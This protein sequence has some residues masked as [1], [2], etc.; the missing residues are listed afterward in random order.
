MRQEVRI[1]QQLL[2]V[3]SFEHLT[4]GGHD[5]LQPAPAVHALV[6]EARLPQRKTILY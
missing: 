1:S 3:L 2:H 5:E 6:V 4:D